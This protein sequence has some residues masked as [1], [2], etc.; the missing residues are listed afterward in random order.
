M[1]LNVR[2]KWQKWRFAV[3]LCMYLA[4][5]KIRNAGED[6]WRAQRYIA[7]TLHP[8]CATQRE[9]TEGVGAHLVDT[10]RLRH[11]FTAQV[12]VPPPTRL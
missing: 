2:T 8:H 1:C 5:Q 6:I 12:R 10:V 7:R 11:P 9:G 3:C 4:K